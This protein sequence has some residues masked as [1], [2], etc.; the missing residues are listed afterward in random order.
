LS[1]HA[2]TYGAKPRFALLPP[3]KTENFSSGG[4]AGVLGDRMA[5]Q[6]A[7]PASFQPRRP[8]TLRAC[9]ALGFSFSLYKRR[10][11]LVESSQEA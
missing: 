4:D 3:E 5:R 6:Q 8:E 10:D 11:N 9:A 7:R 1:F 2:Y